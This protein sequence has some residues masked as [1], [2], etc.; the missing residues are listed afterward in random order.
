M[1][2]CFYYFGQARHGT[3]IFFRLFGVILLILS[4]SEIK[5]ATVAGGD[6]V[7]NI[8]RDALIANIHVDNYPD[9]PTPDFSI[10][11]RPSL[12]VEEFWDASA[13]SKNFAELRDENTPDLYDNIPDEI[14]ATNLQFAVNGAT[15][16]P[17]PIGRQNRSTT[18]TFD[19]SDLTGSVAGRVGLAGV[20]RFRIDVDP[21]TNRVLAGDYTLEYHPEME[22]QALGR[23][24][25][26]LMNQIGF[27]IVG[28]TLFDVNTELT[29]DNFAL[30]GVLGLGEG[31]DHLQGVR[32]ARVGTFSFETAVV[33][34]PAAVWL[35]VS[36]LTSLGLA[37][38]RSKE[39][40]R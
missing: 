39:T 23:S 40:R 38:H 14:P 17:N 24:G 15:I 37:A 10:C 16:A 7:M 36:G 6:F 27:P 13:L 35:F 19:P 1:K 18:L 12:Y 29:A 32:D 26:L 22:D 20:I 3:F 9:E 21:P 31:F 33:P 8:D 34:I 2:N 11:C 30:T 25:W 4:A 28:F 5:A